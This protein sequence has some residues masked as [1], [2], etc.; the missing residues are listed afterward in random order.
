L[1]QATA[2]TRSGKGHPRKQSK[3]VL[4]G[5]RSTKEGRTVAELAQAL[6]SL[7]EH[8]AEIQQRKK[9]LNQLNRLFNIALN[10]MGRGLSMFDANHRLI[11]CNKLYRDIYGLPERLTRPGTLLASLI[12]YHVK[13]ETGRDD[14]KEI[15]TQCQWIESHVSKLTRGETFTYTQHLKRGRIV[16]VTNQPLGAGGWVDI[17][18]D[19]TERRK[20]EQKIE[21]LAHHDPLTD[22]ANRM[23]FGKEL[24]NAL[25]HLIP[26]TGFA[27]HW[28]DL[29][30]FKEINDTFGH[31]V[32][33]AL[34]RVVAKRLV[35]SVRKPDVVARLGGDEFA[36]IQA[37]AKTRMEAERLTKRMLGAIGEPYHVLGHEISIG[38][39]IGVVL[40]PEHGESA[41]ELMT[42]VD[43]ALYAAKAAGRRTYNIFERALNEMPDDR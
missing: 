24:Q 35:K 42:R 26:G 23:H 3:E 2:P 39:S 14:P 17:Q 21:W 6:T 5:A 30:R 12:R 33:D 38:A 22:V 41:E 31:P 8:T 13:R 34:L 36:I 18:E 37:G 27:L 15:E 40:A 29:D 9:Q 7:R 25:R 32:G 1:P 28:I 20:A 10:N 19:V 11:V 4:A 16:L 43:L